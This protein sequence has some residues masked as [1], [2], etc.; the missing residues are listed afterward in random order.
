MN[1]NLL[2]AFFAIGVA[3]VA[4]PLVVSMP[5]RASAGEDMLQSFE[6]IMQPSNVATT[7]DYYDNV[8][9]PLGQVAPALNEETVAKFQGYLQ[10]MS[11][12]GAEGEKLMGTLAAQT[13]MTPVELRAY[14]AKEYPSMTALLQNMPQLEK[15]FGGLMAM[16]AANTEVFS[17]VPAGLAHYKPLVDTMKTNV[18]N[19]DEVSSLPNF[20]LFTAFFVVPGALLVLLAGVALFAGRERHARRVTSP[21][22]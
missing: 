4:A 10:G 20:N 12:M 14:M 21:T 2:W 6:P 18:D 11:G 15:D 17:R 9:V 16:M 22:H 5:T 13:G 7:V 8:F 19:Y 3:L 1:R